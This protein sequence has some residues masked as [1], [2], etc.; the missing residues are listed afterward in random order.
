MASSGE[1]GG[2]AGKE[3]VSGS[4]TRKAAISCWESHSGYVR[5]GRPLLRQTP[6]PSITASLVSSPLAW[7]AHR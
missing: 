6:H 4:R 7:L 2:S 3:P 1:A 5:T